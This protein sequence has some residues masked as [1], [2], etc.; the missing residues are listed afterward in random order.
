MRRALTVLLVLVLVAGVV[1]SGR[2]P[3]TAQKG[4]VKIGFVVPLSGPL[5][6]NGKDTVNGLQMF[7]DEHGSR[8]GGREVK[9]ILEDDEGKPATG[10]TK[11]RSLV[12][13]QGP[14]LPRRVPVLDVQ[15]RRVSQGARLLA[16]QP[17]VQALLV[18]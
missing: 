7:L 8:L 16:R 1:L 12:E 18:S 14:H 13:S 4:P 9:L 10:L 2:A 17:A 15:A 3:A 6:A 5:A 11:A